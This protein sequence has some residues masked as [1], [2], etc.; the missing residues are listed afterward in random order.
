VVTN[1]DLQTENAEVRNSALRFFFRNNIAFD[2]DFLWNPEEDIVCRPE[3]P[4][5]SL[6]DGETLDGDDVPVLR[7]S[8]VCLKVGGPPTSISGVRQSTYADTRAAYLNSVGTELDPYMAGL[9]RWYAPNRSAG[10]R[11]FAVATDG[12]QGMDVCYVMRLIHS[13]DV[14]DMNADPPLY[15]LRRDFSAIPA[16]V[17]DAGW[18][19]RW[20][21]NADVD[22]DGRVTSDDARQWP[23]VCAQPP[24]GGNYYDLNADSL[25][26]RSDYLD[27][28]GFGTCPGVGYSMAN[29]A[30][31]VDIN[32]ADLKCQGEADP[33]D[34]YHG[35]NCFWQAVG[36]DRRGVK[37][38]DFSDIV[39]QLPEAIRDMVDVSG[40]TSVGLHF[41]AG[42]DAASGNNPSF[43]RT[44]GAYETTPVVDPSSNRSSFDVAWVDD[45]GRPALRFDA[46]LGTDVRVDAEPML[47][48]EVQRLRLRV[49]LTPYVCGETAQPACYRWAK[50]WS[51][52]AA[53]WAFWEEN[54]SGVTVG[55][56]EKVAPG[57]DGR[58]CAAD[59]PDRPEFFPDW[60]P[61]P[62][63]PPGFLPLHLASNNLF[64]GVVVDLTPDYDVDW[65]AGCESF[66]SLCGIW[67]A[68][69][70]TSL[71][72]AIAFGWL[73][74]GW[75][76]IFGTAMG[77]VITFCGMTGAC[78]YG[79]STARQ[80]IRERLIDTRLQFANLVAGIA[81]W[82]TDRTTKVR[83]SE[84]LLAWWEEV[85]V[86]G[87]AA[88]GSDYLASARHYLHKWFWRP[89]LG[90]LEEASARFDEFS[91]PDA[92]V[93]GIRFTQVAWVDAR[94]DRVRLGFIWDPD[95]DG[96]DDAVDDN[97]PARLCPWNATACHNPGQHDADGD[98][99]GD[100]CEYDDDADHCCECDPPELE[101]PVGYCAC[102]AGDVDPG[103]P[104]C[105][106]CFDAIPWYPAAGDTDA[107][108]IPDDCD[109]DADN[110]GV[111]DSED[112]CAALANPLQVDYDGDGMGNAC[113]P[114][115]DQ[116]ETGCVDRDECRLPQPFPPGV[117]PELTCTFGQWR[118]ATADLERDRA[119]D[120][121]CD[122]NGNGV[123]DDCSEPDDEVCVWTGYLSDPMPT[124]IPVFECVRRSI[125]RPRYCGLTRPP[126]PMG[127][128][129]GGP[130]GGPG[131]PFD[132]C[133]RDGIGVG[134]CGLYGSAA[135]PC[136]TPARPDCCWACDRTEV[137][138]LGSLGR[139]YRVFDVPQ[140]AGLDAD[141][142]FGGGIAVLQ[143]QDGDGVRDLAVGAPYLPDSPGRLR[144]SV[145]LLSGSDGSVMRG[146]PHDGA[147]GTSVA[148]VEFRLMT[149]FD[150]HW[151]PT[152]RT[153]MA[154]ATDPGADQPT[155]RGAL[156]LDELGFVAAKVTTA[157]PG[158]YALGAT[159]TSVMIGPNEHV[160]LRWADCA[161]TLDN[162]CVRIIDAAGGVFEDIG[163]GTAG[164][165]F[166][167]AIDSDQRYLVV[168]APGAEGGRGV[169]HVFDWRDGS[170][171]IVRDGQD[172]EFGRALAVVGGTYGPYLVVFGEG[173]SGPRLHVMTPDGGLVTNYDLPDDAEL[174]R[175]VSPFDGLRRKGPNYALVYRTEDGWVYHVWT[176]IEELLG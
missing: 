48:V 11:P 110:D 163:S 79:E 85:P 30:A 117:E 25:Y 125:A 39:D 176:G 107:D 160:A 170:H 140:S 94:R 49:K 10:E 77:N 6:P 157:Y 101:P 127:G 106:P 171:R 93:S 151:Q 143:D 70:A 150:E 43:C 66:A 72:M 68:V 87:A 96:L 31:G 40:P 88:P 3:L 169:V 53:G 154:A 26:R 80:T 90:G 135:L 168:G 18:V 123:A 158:D 81:Y 113:D 129:P 37:Q 86:S 65:L 109:T 108:T 162:G 128:G 118:S 116:Y 122:F 62:E 149:T 63:E 29:C 97:C 33:D 55:C 84:G 91:L 60:S 153:A 14:G 52:A 173:F 69:A 111:R 145:L 17:C 119:V 51:D 42:T 61:A 35:Y 71:G 175:I 83:R 89:T 27:F 156:L 59:G 15:H 78:A 141:D 98:R 67:S 44:I 147:V 34:D 22:G 38:F 112:N 126:W 134:L 16:L 46:A 64:F 100:A 56:V 95:Q 99:V 82:G 1:D 41:A 19:D 132:L 92:T 28:L 76:A 136:G 174:V 159:A 2:L 58:L 104:A 148:R 167:H 12:F 164:D 32:M 20:F 9:E 13:L 36:I 172:R 24:I 102:P 50:K 155:V 142:L 115:D 5:G 73:Y 137:Y 8:A 54:W 161:G 74:P 146:S 133:I 75:W 121:L 23:T 166:G 103:D 4:G 165:R 21:R 124:R 45:G 47:G 138:E 120:P 105:E 131:S 57:A 130:G 139:P 152:G 114:D 144:G 7:R